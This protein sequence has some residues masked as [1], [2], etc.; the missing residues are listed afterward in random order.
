MATVNQLQVQVSLQQIKSKF[1]EKTWESAIYFAGTLR[2]YLNGGK[3]FTGTV[4]FTVNCKNGGIGNIE[5]F[6]QKKIK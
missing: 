2:K 5:A 3:D 6:V 1:G 4:V